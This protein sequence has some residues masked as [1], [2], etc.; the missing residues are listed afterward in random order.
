MAFEFPT[1][2]VEGQITNVGQDINY[3]YRNG[4]WEM[5]AEKFGSTKE[6]YQYIATDGQTE[7]TG[8]D[9]NDKVL[10]YTPRYVDVLVNGIQLLPE[11]YIATDGSTI[12]LASGVSENDDVE[13]VANGVFGIA[14][15]YGKAEMDAILDEQTASLGNEIWINAQ[16]I[17]QLKLV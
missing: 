9:K 14:D 6:K 3:I 11:E 13:I 17:Q 10:K 2:P 5:Y 4:M 12:V 16:N 8:G 7:F 15:V 1:S